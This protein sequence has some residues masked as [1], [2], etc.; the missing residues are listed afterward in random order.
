MLK[1]DSIINLRRA[2]KNITSKSFKIWS[3]RLNSW[4]KRRVKRPSKIKSLSHLTWN[5]KTFRSIRESS[6]ASSTKYWCHWKKRT[7]LRIGIC[8]K[9]WIVRGK[10][11]W[12]S[13]KSW[14]SPP[15]T[16]RKYSPS[17][18]NPMPRWRIASRAWSL[19]PPKRC[20]CLK[21][22]NW[23]LEWV[24]QYQPSKRPLTTMVKQISSGTSPTRRREYN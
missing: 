18:I 12:P 21:L 14:Q 4:A 7:F 3:N 17:S 9:I 8:T 16:A 22:S 24:R 10:S 13:S 15:L 19:A 6:K 11:S 5:S 2:M 23:G 1:I 20:G